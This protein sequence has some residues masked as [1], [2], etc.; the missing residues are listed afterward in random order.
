MVTA[1][2]R[3]GDRKGGIG[4]PLYEEKDECR[5]RAPARYHVGEVDAEMEKQVRV[6]ALSVLVDQSCEAEASP[7]WVLSP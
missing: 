7:A 4:K 2:G 5:G 3:E 6:N 1:A